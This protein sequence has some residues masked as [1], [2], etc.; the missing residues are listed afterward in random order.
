MAHIGIRKTTRFWLAA[1]IGMIAVSG[2]LAFAGSSSVHGDAADGSFALRNIGKYVAAAPR[3]EPPAYTQLAS[4][5]DGFTPVSAEVRGDAHGEQ[6]AP[7]RGP[8]SIRA[9]IARY[10]EERNVPRAQVRQS[11]EGRPP[12][13]AAYRN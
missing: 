4:R 3:V 7:M 9:D 10:N 12:S 1:A 2:S 5:T 6:A 8:G 11:D 13:N